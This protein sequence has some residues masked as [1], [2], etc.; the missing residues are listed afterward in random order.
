MLAGLNRIGL[1]ALCLLPA[2]VFGAR[3]PSALP[4]AT[5]MS[6][7]GGSGQSPTV[8]KFYATAHRPTPRPKSA[9]VE[10][11]EGSAKPGREYEP[12]GIVQVLAHVSGTGSAELTERAKQ[13]ALQM[14][15]DALVSVQVDD[16]A[17]TRPPVGEVGRL[18]LVASVVR[19]S[20]RPSG[21]AQ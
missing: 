7:C 13:A 2:L 4:I 6:A 20:D 19:W 17:H 12:V 21:V 8:R 14:G 16:A 10:V 9:P 5:Y 18:A 11:F 3:V 15:G 1:L